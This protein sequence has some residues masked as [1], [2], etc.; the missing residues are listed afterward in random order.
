MKKN[1]KL[2]E[3][4]LKLRNKELNPELEKEIMNINTPEEMVAWYDNRKGPSLE[5]IKKKSPLKYF[6]RWM[7]WNKIRIVYNQGIDMFVDECGAGDFKRA[8]LILKSRDIKEEEFEQKLPQ[9]ISNVYGS[10]EEYKKYGVSLKKV[11]DR[12]QKLV[13]ET[14]WGILENQIIKKRVAYPLIKGCRAESDKILEYCKRTN[15]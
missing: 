12:L 4:I 14:E 7:D 10:L 9:L 6:S 15:P 1:I 5:E 8:R 2:E 3:T 13:D 11:A